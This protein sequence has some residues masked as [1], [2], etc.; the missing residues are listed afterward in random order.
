M[1][2]KSIKINAKAAK[3]V[4]TGGILQSGV[5]A[6]VVQAAV[7]YES[8]KGNNM[9]NL[10]LKSDDGGIAYINNICIDEEWVSGS[11]NSNYARSQ[12]FFMVVGAETLKLKDKVIKLNNG[13]KKDVWEVTNV[14]GKKC[15]VSIYREYG[16]N[17][18]DE[19]RI[20]T[21]LSQ[22]FLPSGK[23]LT[24]KDEKEDAKVIESAKK[25]TKDN[26]TKEWVKWNK[27]G[28]KE[29]DVENNYGDDDDDEEMP[30]W[31]KPAKKEKKKKKK[32]KK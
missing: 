15:Q 12:E 11:E 22:T 21:K 32:N 8:A 1:G 17:D 6:V 10:E 9:L 16:V 5:H 13:K 29:A 23:T 2:K 25:K 14:I 3:S 20:E 28:T 19:E 18:S 31:D 7:I 26:H 27:S 30:D 4:K 24:E